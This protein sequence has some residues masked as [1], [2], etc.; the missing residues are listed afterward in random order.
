M[1]KFKIFGK[2]QVLVGSFLVVALSLT[3]LFGDNFL[4]QATSPTKLTGCLSTNPGLLYSLKFGSSPISPCPTGDP[5]VS[6]ISEVKRYQSSGTGIQ[7]ITPVDTWMDI[8]N[9]SISGTFEAGEWKATYT[10]VLGVTNGDG[11]AIVRFQI[12]PESGSPTNVGSISLYQSSSVNTTQ[13]VT[14]PFT[15]QSLITLPGGQ[16]SVVP[17]VTSNNTEFYF[18]TGSVLILEK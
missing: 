4:A 12:R 1:K 5:E 14:Q 3:Y 9:A 15:L 8:P 7:Y 10:G 2:R 17:Q 13:N 18:L 16:V 6:L 11:T